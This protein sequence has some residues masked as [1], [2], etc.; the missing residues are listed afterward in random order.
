MADQTIDAIKV[1]LGV[2]TGSIEAGVRTANE[3]LDKIG[4]KTR[5]VR[6][7][8]EAVRS[9]AGND[10]SLHSYMK[11]AR[12]GAK[13]GIEVPISVKANETGEFGIGKLRTKIAK[14]LA[15]GGGV[16]VPIQVK[17]S[18]T[19]A[20][21]IRRDIQTQIG[22]V[23]IYFD[24]VARNKP[25]PPPG[26]AAAGGGGGGRGGG[27]AP[28]GGTGTGGGAT[29][30][31]RGR[32]PG[33][34]RKQASDR[35]KAEH[36]ARQAQ[37]KADREA[38]KLSDDQRKL[39]E[40][41]LG[42][43][44][45]ERD[46]LV[47]QLGP[48]APAGG[49]AG[50]GSRPRP[51]RAQKT[52]TGAPATGT[53]T[54]GAAAAGAYQ[55]HRGTPLTGQ[56]FTKNYRTSNAPRGFG[57]DYDYAPGLDAT[58]VRGQQG[59]GEMRAQE[60]REEAMAA[61]VQKM[62]DAGVD[63][64]DADEARGFLSK[65]KGSARRKAFQRLGPPGAEGDPLDDPQV[66]AAF[67]GSLKI[68]GE[69]YGGQVE[70]SGGRVANRL[71]GA[72]KGGKAG[73]GGGI[74]GTKGTVVGASKTRPEDIEVPK[75]GQEWLNAASTELGEGAPSHQVEALA[76]QNFA[77]EEAKA[78]K[79]RQQIQERSIGARPPESDE[80]RKAREQRE[81]ADAAEAR[82]QNKRREQIR[83]RLVQEG[84]PAGVMGERIEA[85]MKA[86][87]KRS[88]AATV[89]PKI[90]PYQLQMLPGG[91]PAFAANYPTALAQS[92]VARLGRL[93][94][95]AK[96]PRLSTA[97][98][99]GAMQRAKLSAEMR[100]DE[101]FP[102]L[103][104]RAEGGQVRHTGLLGRMAAAGH[105]PA[106]TLLGERG[107]E[108]AITD[109]KGESEVV[110]THQVPTWLQR[111][112]EGKGLAKDLTR[113]QEGGGFTF[114]GQRGFTSTP[115]RVVN[116]QGMIQRVFVVNWPAAMQ[117]AAGAPAQPVAGAGI[118]N[119]VNAINQG[120]ARAGGAA[121]GGR[122]ARGGGAGA[123][124]GG[125]AAAGGAGAGGAAAG[126][127]AGG[128][129]AA[130]PAFGPGVGRGARGARLATGRFNQRQL[131]LS[132]IQSQIS[133]AQSLTP[134]RAL[135]VSFGQITSQLT[136]RAEIQARARRAARLTTQAES[137]LRAESGERSKLAD[138]LLLERR[139]R[140]NL[141][142]LSQ[143]ETNEL[144]RLPDAI[145]EQRTRVERS[146]RTALAKQATA[147][148]AAGGVITTGAA[149]KNIVAGAAGISVGTLAFS[150]AYGALNAG[151]ETFVDLAGK[152]IERGSGYRNV[153]AAITKELGEQTRA[154]K[155]AAE[156]T[157]ALAA[158]QA[159]LSDAQANSIAPLLQRRALIEGGNQAFQDQLDLIRTAR[160]AQ[161]EETASRMGLSAGPLQPPGGIPG[162]TRSTGGFFGSPINATPSLFENLDVAGGTTPIQSVIREILGNGPAGVFGANELRTGAEIGKMAEE[163]A[164]P[165]ELISAANQLQTFGDTVVAMDEALGKVNS[166]FD[167]LTEN[168]DE[169]TQ[170]ASDWGLKMAGVPDG[171]IKNFNK[172]GIAFV[173][174]DTGEAIGGREDLKALGEDIL[175][176]NVLPDPKQLIKAMTERILPAQIA[177][178]KREGSFE[179]QAVLPAQTALRFAAQPQTPFLDPRRLPSGAE[180]AGDYR[181]AFEAYA[182]VALPAQK[183]I[184]AE[185]DRGRESLLKMGVPPALL[186]DITAIGKQIQSIQLGVQQRGLNLQV[187]EYNNQLRIA[188]RSLSDAKDFQAG[189]R[190]QAGETLGALEGQNAAMSRQLQLLQLELTQRQINFKL[191]TA[192]FVAPGTTPEERAARIEAA[193]T[194]AEFAQKQL[195]LQKQ[196]AANQFQTVQ[197]GAGRNVTDLQAQISL[198]TQG[199]ALTI[200]TAAAQAAIEALQEQQNI[201]VEK[202]QSYAAQS[203]KIAA[204]W[205][206]TWTDIQ[207]QSGKVLN[208][209]GTELA[210]AFSGAGAAFVAAIQ[211]ATNPD[212][213]GPTT[214]N[215]SGGPDDRGRQATGYTGYHATPTTMTIGEAA[216]EEVAILR[217][218]RR[219]MMQSMGGGGGGMNIGGI[220][221]VVNGG[222]NQDQQS[223]TML[224]EAIARKVE[225]R[226]MQKTNLLGIRRN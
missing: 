75:W 56:R 174:K 60:G 91:G 191:A 183:A 209:L 147:T 221:V 162:I 34:T 20:Q 196:I 89:A 77:A 80:V 98:E 207:T 167:I 121:A 44:K 217:N 32:Q 135:S 164:P 24:W 153:T 149:V 170:K 52:A 144:A 199:K 190:G 39:A 133:E 2:D 28:A 31:G 168:V 70:V 112:K 224:A 65:M 222:S 104:A 128:G 14:A 3:Q 126:G 43:L 187:A 86:V 48:E 120:F 102:R 171:V 127:A 141:A 210:E 124:G 22:V 200:D 61:F 51:P 204:L 72:R 6:V 219:V 195:D 87:P 192:G 203:Q 136:G 46:A 132:D 163:G 119:I 26:A 100:E 177:G 47:S 125:G 215:S 21:K 57:T 182:D 139:Y 90:D 208:S 109:E 184:S 134:V 188:N 10:R 66:L 166:K 155:G 23:Q 41:E 159:G 180:A 16:N 185:I 25:E 37:A 178:I 142:S 101:G 116:A 123:G 19:D 105:Q 211:N 160:M 83:K 30:T 214:P 145:R 62:R 1:R 9:G 96:L 146:N 33:E 64:A 117:A 193:K 156:S 143:K 194:E 92:M 68:S 53:A 150:A 82:E 76:R 63:P 220:T 84:V 107:P 59:L 58:A 7:R 152:A 173:Q 97:E 186:D 110:P 54:S 131:E 5:V 85:E 11:Q 78:L 69:H 138:M 113:R 35:N 81:A 18:A 50:T 122:G 17:L 118:Q 67:L 161:S 45:K 115:G 88:Q 12:E 13:K 169:A 175:Q 99:I 55:P 130:T 40:R 140:R 95:A 213:Y 225:E 212:N 154:N 201:L 15:V 189:I 218:P 103:T 179:R 197:I 158:A 114:R 181:K 157:V 205:M 176:G 106:I 93:R 36:A 206:N 71:A 4:S 202:A 165:E 148:E 216:G 94:T 223:A 172:L 79:M 74:A 8:V 49:V 137:A 129:G 27:G 226:L 29:P 198:L 108:L 111:A 38:Q 42:E 151:V 73:G